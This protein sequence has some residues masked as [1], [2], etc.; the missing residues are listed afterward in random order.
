MKLT[1]SFRDAAQIRQARGLDAFRSREEEENLRAWERVV[2]IADELGK[3]DDS[4]IVHA[5]KELQELAHKRLSFADELGFS[6]EDL[7]SCETASGMIVATEGV[8]SASRESGLAARATCAAGV[9]CAATSVSFSAAALDDAEMFDGDELEEVVLPSSLRAADDGSSDE[10]T[11]F[12]A[13]DSVAGGAFGVAVTAA[14]GVAG[15]PSDMNASTA[16]GAAGNEIPELLD[17]PARPAPAEVATF[18]HLCAG[19]DGKLCLFEDADGHLV[20]VRASRL[21]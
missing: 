4:T 18:K 2:E 15:E 13:G 5:M 8:A 10:A 19:R 14:S 6:E 11:V 9:D 12:T 17:V 1:N 21:A 7:E 3:C 16:T 20:A